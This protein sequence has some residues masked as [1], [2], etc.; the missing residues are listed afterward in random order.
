MFCL[1]PGSFGT[2]RTAAVDAVQALWRIGGLAA[3]VG[4]AAEGCM[5]GGWR[6]LAGGPL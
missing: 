6:V 5:L 4:G 3:M 1:G 2:Q